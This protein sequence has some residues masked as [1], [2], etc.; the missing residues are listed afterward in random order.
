[1]TARPRVLVTGAS[2]LIGG[3]LAV[4]L[5]RDHEVIA[6]RHRAAVPDGL[7]AVDAELL[8]PRSLAAAFE[9]AR[10]GA[11][12]H[13]AAF[14]DADRCEAEPEAAER[15]NSGAGATLARLCHA[16]GVRLVGVSTDLV[17]AGERAWST[18]DV[19]P[20][21]CLVYGRTKL[22]GERTMMAEAPDAAVVRLP[23]MLGRGY[24]RRA[25]SS[26]TIAR[27]LAAGERLRLFTDQYRS[28]TDPESVADAV[29]L[30]L[31][32][33]LSG[34]VHLGGPERLSRHELGLRVARVMGLS[35]ATI[36]P[37]TQGTF[38]PGRRRP[39]DTSLDSTRA[40]TELGWTPR[41]IDDAIR[42]SRL[43]A[44]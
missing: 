30:L 31:R 43:G 40:R 27:A 10:P 28:S 42:E 21:P 6:M 13:A 20:A 22:E 18:E 1:M 44:V 34:L 35:P 38:Q 19:L 36:E 15:L 11:A 32:R 8:D 26:E 25:T 7:A 3:R 9:R 24:G 39:A 41:P 29:S 17:L 16:H 37:V 33:P 2:G 4:L 23:L 14:A 12:V 5:A